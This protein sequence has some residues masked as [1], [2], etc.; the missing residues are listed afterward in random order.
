MTVNNA[1]EVTAF[2]DSYA[3]SQANPSSTRKHIPYVPN[4][5]ANKPLG[6]GYA[7]IPTSAMLN[8]AAPTITFTIYYGATKTGESTDNGK[9]LL[10]ESKNMTVTVPTGG[11]LEGNVYNVILNIPPPEAVDMH[12]TLDVWEV[13]PQNIDLSIE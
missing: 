7:M 4:G 6:L 2:S 9:G 8:N 3:F 11:F 12:A 5:S 1:G 13:V 10:W